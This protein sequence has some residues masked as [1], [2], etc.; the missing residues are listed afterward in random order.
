M[1]TEEFARLPEPG[2]LFEKLIHASKVISE[3]PLEELLEFYDSLIPVVE[4]G[5][6][7]GVTP[8]RMRDQVTGLRALVFHAIPLKKAYIENLIRL[9]ILNNPGSNTTN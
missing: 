2:G 8:A 7:E 3:L 5:I 4:H 1:T 6:Q 9:G